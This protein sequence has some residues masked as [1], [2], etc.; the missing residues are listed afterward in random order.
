MADTAA[1]LRTSLSMTA[2]MLIL[3]FT[4]YQLW[5]LAHDCR[6]DHHSLSLADVDR[7]VN[8]GT[9]PVDKLHSYEVSLALN[10]FLVWLTRIAN[11]MY[12][13]DNEV[14]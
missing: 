6:L 3:C 8:D 1:F 14:T 10:D 12:G 13:Q 2:L 9:C 11:A 4:S 7:I 5:I